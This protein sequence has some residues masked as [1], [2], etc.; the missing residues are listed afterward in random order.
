MSRIRLPS[1]PPN[2]SSIVARRRAATLLSLAGAALALVVALA[3]FASTTPSEAQT[4]PT[5]NIADASAEEGEN[6]VFI[7]SLSAPATQEVT[8]SQAVTAL[9]ADAGTGGD[10]PFTPHVP[11]ISVGST[12]T[13]L[14]YTSYEDDEK[15]PDE[16]FRIE[17]VNIVGAVGG[18]T[19]AIGTILN[20]DFGT[21]TDTPTNL[22]VA[23]RSVRWV[24]LEW[25]ALDA[26]VLGWRINQVRYRSSGG[27]NPWIKYPGVNFNTNVIEVHDLDSGATYDFQV[28]RCEFNPWVNP[29]NPRDAD[30]GDWSGTASGTTDST[31]LP[32]PTGFQLFVLSDTAIQAAWEIPS[33]WD[34]LSPLGPSELQYKPASVSSYQATGSSYV[35]T[36]SEEYPATGLTPNTEY[37]FRVRRCDSLSNCSAWVTASATTNEFPFDP[38]LAPSGLSATVSGNN[39]VTLDWSALDSDD[40]DADSYEYR[41]KAGSGSYG[42]PVS[43]QTMNTGVDTKGAMVSGLTRETNYYFQVRAVN[44]AGPSEWSDEARIRI[45]NTPGDFQASAHPTQIDG[46]NL[47]WNPSGSNTRYEYQWKRPGDSAWSSGGAY[48]LDSGSGRCN[49]YRAHVGGLSWNTEYV[50]RVRAITANA[51]DGGSRGASAW[52]PERRVRITTTV[53]IWVYGAEATEGNALQFV[54][55]VTSPYPQPLTFSYAVSALSATSPADFTATSG[56]VTLPAN[57]W[58]ATV[59]VNTA[60]DAEVESAEHVHLRITGVGL[61]AAVEI[62][63][64]QSI[65]EISDND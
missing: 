23:K 34:T 54:I 58:T 1:P 5:L 40:S 55:G 27:D 63:D 52:S 42:S 41:Q 29:S 59:T 46:V 57:A 48:R 6:L 39:Q 43:A 33:Q 14:T 3:L 26:R 25:N 36:Q 49:C 61:P 16:T 51:N 15:E 10:F 35:R 32:A 2:R 65:G 50:F 30:C 13:T 19:T 37:D 11:T 12:S 4:L 44:R 47:R 28:R 21:L 64:G 17:I 31:T 38:P 56:T 18:D 53:S 62:V 20:D 45:E 9:T 7:I 24:R 60:D 22:R 8:F